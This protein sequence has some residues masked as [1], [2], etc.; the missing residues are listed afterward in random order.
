M[1]LAVESRYNKSKA[2]I[3]YFENTAIDL[4]NNG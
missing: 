1:E 2:I 3:M 4:L